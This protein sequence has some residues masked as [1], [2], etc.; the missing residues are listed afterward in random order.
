MF[1]GTYS[2][3]YF[4]SP[5][6]PWP[7][8]FALLVVLLISSVKEGVE[9]LERY[10]CDQI[11]NDLMVPIVTFDKETCMYKEI[12]KPSREIRVGDIVKFE[13]R[14][15]IPADIVILFTSNYLDNNHCFVETSNIDGEMNLKQKDGLVGVDFSFFS[16]GRTPEI[17]NFEG[18]IEYEPPNKNVYNFVGALHFSSGKKVSVPL[19]A[20]NLLLRGSVF[21]NTEWGYGV[22]VYTG[23]D[24]KI[25]L[26]TSPC[27]HV[28]SRLEKHAN[29]AVAC[30]F[31]AQILV[32]SAAVLCMY[33]VGY[34]RL[35]QIPYVYRDSNDHGSVLPLWL[36]RWFVIFL[37]LNNF[38]PI[39]LYVQM[40]MVNIG[41]SYLIS[42]D[43][44]LYDETIDSPCIVKSS[45]MCQEIGCVTHIFTDKT[46][47]LT[48]NKMEFVRFVFDENVYNLSDKVLGDKRSLRPFLMSLAL[49]HTAMK[50]EK[51]RYRA[52]SMD[53]VALLEGLERSYGIR[54]LKRTNNEL[55]LNFFDEEITMEI[56]L[57]ND[58]D[59][60]RKRMSI[61][62]RDPCKNVYTLI[63]KGADSVML[64]LCSRGFGKQIQWK[65]VEDSL[66]DQSNQ[67]LRTL[68]VARKE[69]DEETAKRWIV[70]WKAACTSI[71]GRM[72]A[73]AASVV[74]MER[75]MEYLGF[76]AIEDKLQ[77]EVPEVLSS[78]VVAGIVVWML[79]GDK[80]ETAINVGYACNLLHKDCELLFITETTSESSLYYL[81]STTRT[82]ICNDHVSKKVA[83]V[84]EGNAFKYF[85]EKQE[86]MCKLFLD[87]TS[88]C[89]SVI[90]C[91][92][93]PAQKQQ[94]V[95]FIR[96]KTLKTGRSLTLAI[97]D[98]ANDVSMIREAD[99]GV[100]IIGKEGNQAAN[101]A[102]FAIGQFKFLKRLLL[103]HGRWN[104]VRQSNNF[105][106][107]LHKNIVITVTLF[108]FC[109]LDYISGA[110]PFETWIYGGYNFALGWPIVFLAVFDRDISA[111][112]ALNNPE[113]YVTGRHYTCLSYTRIGYYIMNAFIYG[114]IIS[115]FVYSVL[116]YTLKDYG[117]FEMGTLCF[118]A[119]LNAMQLKVSFMHHQWNFLNFAAM[120]ISVG[121]SI[122]VCLY[123]SSWEEYDYYHVMDWSLA[124]LVFWLF[125]HLIVPVT[126]LIVDL[127]VHSF[128]LFFFPSE[129]M[130]F[131]ERDLYMRQDEFLTVK[132]VVPYE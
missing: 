117:L 53:E 130:I 22:A 38:I 115:L 121:G 82:K 40:E 11:E 131:R 106:Y 44:E 37:L 94:F 109:F 74:D 113:S 45:N 127:L 39:S 54:L 72:E 60:I 43:K 2:N 105:L 9:D 59:S 80:V 99:V 64:P 47:T 62:V 13:G 102:D 132:K 81:L 112:Y 34:H 46:G 122:C 15:V 114:V 76:T 36:E 41:Q 23:A 50:D 108:W 91:R 3:D 26:N 29:Y 100:G 111:S 25:Q 120:A 63:C 128:R 86:P 8:T 96:V 103:V 12:S 88:R 83:L 61:L 48:A 77:D 84:I 95:R 56:L 4:Q 124:Q 30:I 67:G 107:C 93:T 24:T 92:M 116:T 52:E 16:D 27:V 49:C 21:C 17:K 51:G 70:S 33:L 58:F 35:S 14:C 55:K 5:L 85:D 79:T 18:H 31:V 119:I 73:V 66:R 10:R 6:E 123:V 42:N 78:L 104:F 101:A 126:C 71:K 98:G 110:S 32:V 7:P 125:G 65:S 1:V 129:D 75:D 87:I 89:C 20:S 28:L 68:C 69:V 97:G 90:A 118:F 57:V 19:S